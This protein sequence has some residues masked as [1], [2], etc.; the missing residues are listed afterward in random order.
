MKYL[1][2]LM[3]GLAL[4]GVAVLFFL[5][6]Q[7]PRVIESAKPAGDSVQPVRIAYF[8]IDS[9]Q[10]QYKFFQEVADDL[11]NRE[12]SVAKQLNSLQQS[13][14][15][16]IQELQERSPLMTQSEGEAAQ[17]EVAQMQQKFQQRQLTLDQELKKQQLDQMTAVRRKIE[18]FL[19]RYNRE[20]G[21]SFILSYEPG[22]MLYYRDPAFDITQEVIA[23]LNAEYEKEKKQ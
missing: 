6:F 14:Q 16:R 11:R 1:S 9:L 8:H 15:K 5:H 19:A 23:G 7:E 3:S 13:F 4:V 18:D 22:L 17:R 2:P 12:A 21:Y 20:K 10:D